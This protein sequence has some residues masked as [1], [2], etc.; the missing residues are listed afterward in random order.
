MR[1]P[2]N[3][4]TVKELKSLLNQ[5]DDDDYV[6]IW[7]HENDDSFVMANVC[8]SGKVPHDLFKQE[9]KRGKITCYRCK[10]TFV[11]MPSTD[12]MPTYCCPSCRAK[13]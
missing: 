7:L 9:F 6:R 2:V 4:M 8:T 13:I 3:T 11:V 1:E 10:K 12:I 5:C